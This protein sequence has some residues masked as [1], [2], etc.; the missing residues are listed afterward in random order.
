MD[1][2]LFEQGKQAYAERDF[3]TAARSFL[4]AAGDD[5][6]GAGEA[7]SCA[8][9]AL[10]RLNR[11]EDAVTAYEHALEDGTLTRIGAV[12]ANLGSAY[13]A[14]GRY[15]E[16]VE[17][18][19]LALDA[20]DYTNHWKAHQGRAG[21]LYEMGRLEDA[22]ASYRS[23][24]LDGDNPDP[25]KALNNLGLCNMALGD[26]QG[27]VEAYRAAVASPGYAG[28]GRAC[29]NLGLAYSVLGR[30]DAAVAAFR[31]ATDEH[32]FELTGGLA[33]AARMSFDAVTSDAIDA[34]QVVEEVDAEE[35]GDHDDPF[36]DIH[37][38]ESD[39][40]TRTDADMRRMDRETRKEDKKVA[41]SGRAT[42]PRYAAIAAVAVVLIFGL[43][44]AWFSGV[45]YPS[46]RATVA[47]LLDA[48][49]DSAAYESYWVAVPT[50]DIEQEMGK[51]P[52]SYQ[53]E[54][55]GVDSSASEA[56]VDVTVE[57]E[58]GAPLRYEFSLARE[59]V[60]WKVTG[61]EN[62]WRSTGGGS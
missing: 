41:R 8:G 51:L 6:A 37:E 55:D 13:R 24:A 50:T 56:K 48:Y 53:Y 1:Q 58:G 61:L 7:L 11:Y 12:A 52:A 35:D 31:E 9:N 16:A 33:E 62:D 27:A 45:G 15:D 18:F 4:A 29:A 19:D 14:S 20:S 30:H 28:M 46:Q 40:F 3:R 26:P 32:G 38:P 17:A 34:Q 22:A 44:W 5:P 57:L 25:G 10:M 43:S 2:A 60:G 23:A 54:I 47:G 49:R 59:G 39:F 21:A 36:A 42:W